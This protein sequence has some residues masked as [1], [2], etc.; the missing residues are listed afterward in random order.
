M[1]F[2]GLVEARTAVRALERRGE[3]ARLVLAAPGPAWAASPGESLSVSGCCL[4]VAG[5]RDPLSGADLAGPRAGADLVFDLSAETL[6]RTWL[7]AAEPGRAVNLERALTLAGLLGGHLVTGHVDAL[8]TLAGSA[9]PGD[10]GRVLTFEVPEGFERW[11]IDKGSVAV[12]GVSLTV[13][14][15]R[16]RRFDVAL[17]P[18]TLAR[19]TLGTARTGE[20]VH[21]EG[22]AIGKWVEHLSHPWRG[23]RP[24]G[25]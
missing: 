12:D 6:R 4:T 25:D 2:T 15:P 14:D 19:T 8:G 21:L 20:R 22:D 1:V 17:I 10:G 13:V 7:A 5:W 16:G 9:D 3:G 18:E 11:L 24:L 23:A